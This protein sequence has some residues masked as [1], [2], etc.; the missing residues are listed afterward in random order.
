MPPLFDYRCSK[1]GFQTEY[2]EDANNNITRQHAPCNSIMVKQLSAGNF[3]FNG[4]GF[5]KTDY[6][7]K[8][9]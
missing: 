7:D 2:L 1:C 3:K 5:Y 6:K 8:G 4:S 9:K